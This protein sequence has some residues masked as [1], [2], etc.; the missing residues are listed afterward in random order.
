MS[1]GGYSC[2]TNSKAVMAARL[3]QEEGT[4]HLQLMVAE[5]LEDSIDL[6]KDLL[7]EPILSFGSGSPL[8][9]PIDRGR[10]QCMSLNVH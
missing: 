3:P 8:L 9:I 1:Y 2:S 6:P 10:S 7:Q 5:I 4:V